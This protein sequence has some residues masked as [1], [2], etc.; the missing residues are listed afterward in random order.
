MKAE[1]NHLRKSRFL[2]IVLLAILTIP[3]IYTTLFLSSMWNPYGKLSSL[4]VAIVNKDQSVSLNGT[5]IHIGDDLI[6]NLKKSDSLKYYFVS[7]KKANDGL[8]NGRYYMVV[9]IPKGFSKNAATITYASP[10]KM[11]LYYNTNPGTNY[12]ASKMCESAMLHIKEEVSSSVTS[13]YSKNVFTQ[14]RQVKDGFSTAVTGTNTLHDGLAQLLAGETTV[15]NG[16]DTLSNNLHTFKNGATSLQDG[17]DQYTKGVSTLNTNMLSAKN[18]SAALSDGLIKLN[19][20]LNNVKFTKITLSD[21]QKNAISTA[22]SNQV[23]DYSSQLAKGLSDGIATQIQTSLTN[24]DTTNAISQAIEASP[25]IAQMEAALISTGYTKEQ[26]DATISGIVSST[27]Q[28]ASSNISSNQIN[29]GISNSV[30]STMSQ[31]A[32]K[33]AL[34]GANGVADSLNQT[35]GTFGNTL[36]TL[37]ESVSKLSTGATQLNTGLNQLSDG[38][39]QLDQK[40]DTLLNASNSLSTGT[41]KLKAAVDKLHSGSLTL[42]DGLNQSVSGTTDLSNGLTNGYSTLDTS[43]KHVSNQTYHMFSDPLHTKETKIST[44]K[45]NG[46]SMAAYMMTVAMWV[47][48]MSFCLMYPIAQKYSNKKQTALSFWLGKA[49]IMYPFACGFSA[50]MVFALY[51][52]IGLRPHNLKETYFIAMVSAITFMSILYFFNLWL[53]KIGSFLM[54]IFMVVQLSGSG[55]TYPVQLSAAY[56]EK[57]TNFLP[58]TY[59]IRAFRSALSGGIGV[60]YDL[61]VLLAIF[62]VMNLCTIFYLSFWNVKKERIVLPDLALQA[63]S[64]LAQLTD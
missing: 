20:A 2:I 53:K 25:S 60:Q 59:S 62:L 7:E 49:S 3:T 31:V 27:L 51:Q 10:K 36:N 58:F 22:A 45:N 35:L 29:Q 46:T 33:S 44:V 48:G 32:A 14:L 4:P 28:A 55:G 21:E 37:K 17:L 5:S 63:D 47:A 64:D 38:S 18:G 39:A 52:I 13:F 57:I 40:K 11:T 61:T 43:L 23:S 24:Q 30:S 42:E 6:H 50:L 12:I 9:T 54:L 15:S 1:W 56:V 26:A 41:E 34:A 16:L 19:T 8:K